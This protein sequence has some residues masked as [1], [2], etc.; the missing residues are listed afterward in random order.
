MSVS[1]V[2]VMVGDPKLMDSLLKCPMGKSAS[3]ENLNPLVH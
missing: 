3:N 1:E 2:S